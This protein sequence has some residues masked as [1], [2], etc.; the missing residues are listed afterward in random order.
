VNRKDRVLGPRKKIEARALARKFLQGWLENHKCPM[1]V[2]MNWEIIPNFQTH[3]LKQIPE[4][5]WKSTN[6]LAQNE[7]N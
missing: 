4:K 3:P 5:R 1:K 2:A 6:A 7:K